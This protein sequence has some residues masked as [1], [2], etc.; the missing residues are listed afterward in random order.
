MSGPL[1]RRSV[2]VTRAAH[3]SAPLADALR[4]AGADVVE[5]PA[6]AVVPPSN[7]GQPHDDAL[8]R[9]DRFTWVAFTSVNA[10][11]AAFA[12]AERRGVRHRLARMYL[13]KLT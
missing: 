7:G 10:V 1:A 5:A 3:Q 8:M 4:A 9:L 13:Q 12:R 11:A 6:V 2:V